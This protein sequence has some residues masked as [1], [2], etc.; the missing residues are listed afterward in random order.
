MRKCAGTD[1]A[2][3]AGDPDWFFEA[4]RQMADLHVTIEQIDD[5]ICRE[6]WQN[7]GTALEIARRVREPSQ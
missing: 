4:D 1:R 6:A 2:I 5:P 7:L 3:S